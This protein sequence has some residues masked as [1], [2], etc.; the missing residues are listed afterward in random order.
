MNKILSV[1]IA[2]Y[3]AEKYLS[4]CLDSFCVPEI[5]DDIE[6][7]IINDG[8]TDK[9]VEISERYVSKYPNTFILINKKNGGHG[10]T[11]NTGIKAA[12]GKYFKLVDADDWVTKDG[13][14][15]LVN[16][17]KCCSADAIISPYYKFFISRNNMRLQIPFSSHF[18]YDV[19]ADRK[20]KIEKISKL[21]DFYLTT[22]TFNTSILK[23]HF[24][25]ITENCFFVD[26][27]Y[28]AFYS[29]YISDALL[30]SV[31]VYVYRLE[32]EGQSVT[33][34]NMVNRR[35]QNFEVYKKIVKFHNKVSGT[36]TDANLYIVKRLLSFIFSSHVRILLTIND[37]YQSKKELYLFIK[38][39][40]SNNPSLYRD[41]I[42]C[43]IKE[44]MK[45]IM[46][47]VILD[48]TNFMLFSLVY[49]VF[50]F[51]K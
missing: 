24:T 32:N 14:V 39:T 47:S 12:T 37:K 46:I 16:K 3:N 18:K 8:S 38:Y 4:K 2:A 13:I 27:E 28:D 51:F 26:M 6:V 42:R 11:I 23:N 7:L 43:G 49:K 45:P 50:H 15:D 5:M 34:Q 41:I 1:S 30:S 25:A 20:L 48:K 19:Y 21:C 29:C 44:K 10:S 33:P 9:T 36:V 31:P 35:G 40:K 22:L 17:A